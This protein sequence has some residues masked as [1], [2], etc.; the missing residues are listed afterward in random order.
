M[1]LRWQEVAVPLILV[2]VLLALKYVPF[3]AGLPLSRLAGAVAFGYAIFLALRLVQGTE[4]ISVDG[5]DQLRASPVEWFGAAL[6]TL[7][8]GLFL[9]MVLGLGGGQFS[10]RQM[11]LSMALS[12][13]F[14]LIAGG[15]VL[16]SLAPR[17][18]WNGRYVEHRSALGGETR[19]DW[20]DVVGIASRWRGMTIWTRDGRA[21]RF[22]PYQSGAAQLA[23][24]AAVRILNNAR[25]AGAVVVS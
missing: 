24:F 5:W 1:P 23:R 15:I 11:A 2:T 18:R 17:T 22:S 3:T 14:A 16:A 7:L 10:F 19:L 9:A 8:S 21:I 4:A 12:L 13:A 6:F 20:A 25:A